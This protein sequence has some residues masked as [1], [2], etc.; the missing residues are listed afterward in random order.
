MICPLSPKRG[1][2]LRNCV[3]CWRL[4]LSFGQRRLWFL[5]QLDPG[6]SAY[7]I[8]AAV[9]VEGCLEAGTLLQALEHVVQRHEVLRTVFVNSGGDPCQVILDR[10]DVPFFEVDLRQ[11]SAGE[12]ESMLA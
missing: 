8:P 10:M 6:S 1:L 11:H 2:C 5:A 4:P 12:R 3:L 9:R 7:T